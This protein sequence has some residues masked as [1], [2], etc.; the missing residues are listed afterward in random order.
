M[1]CSFYGPAECKEVP[2]QGLECVGNG[3]ECSE[4]DPDRCDGDVLVECLNGK[5]ARFDCS[6]LGDFACR[7]VPDYGPQC[8]ARG[9]ECEA[10]DNSC[11]GSILKYCYEGRFKTFDCASAGFLTCQSNPEY[12][13]AWCA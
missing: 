7:T 8:K 4:E 13:T 11:D 3:A 2:E 12:R 5:E 1:D 6:R 9:T 10:D